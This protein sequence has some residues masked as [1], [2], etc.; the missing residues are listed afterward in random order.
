VDGREED[1]TSEVTS[2]A[3]EAELA[4][5][6]L[7]RANTRVRRVASLEI[8]WLVA[9]FAVGAI[10]ASR[11]DFVPND[12]K[13]ITYVLLAAVA[14]SAWW[15]WHTVR[16]NEDHGDGI[17]AMSYILTAGCMIALLAATLWIA[18][19]ISSKS[20]HFAL[21]VDIGSGV[22]LGTTF[23]LMTP[24]RTVHNPVI[25]IAVRRFYPLMFVL[26]LMLVIT[27]IYAGWVAGNQDDSGVSNLGGSPLDRFN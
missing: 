16:S 4:Q 26:F 21:A 25:E 13:T 24:G 15:Q 23:L 20:M 7:R 3:L 27:A 1:R 10:V 2:S 19:D 18:S 8:T 14:F 6:R 12:A 11:I 17:T 5:L 9:G 22:W